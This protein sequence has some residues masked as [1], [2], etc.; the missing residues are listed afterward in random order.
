[1]S[2]G[3]AALVKHGKGSYDEAILGAK[4]DRF[5]RWHA[6]RATFQELTFFVLMWVLVVAR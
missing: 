6:V 1:M 5:A 4:L 2:R 3:N